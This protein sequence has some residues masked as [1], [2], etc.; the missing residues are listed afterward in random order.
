[1]AGRNRVNEELKVQTEAGKTDIKTVVF[2]YLKYW[3]LILM[4]VAV[5][6]WIGKGYHDSKIP[7]YS[8]SAQILINDDSK[9]AN[10]ELAIFE[11]IAI[12]K[13]STMET[14]ILEMKSVTFIEKIITELKLYVN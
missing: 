13:Q 7:L 4:S 1:M 6:L 11:G 10:N 5:A 3:Y 8:A 14:E 12:E 9:G 2:Q